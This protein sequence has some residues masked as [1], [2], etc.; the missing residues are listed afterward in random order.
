[1]K[2]KQLL[3]LSFFLLLLCTACE[4]A[5]KKIEYGKDACSFC[6]MTIVDKTHSAEI[7]TKKG[8]DYKYDA[9]EC[10]V[11]DIAKK[12][13]NSLAFILVANYANPGELIDATQ[14]TFLI[15]P[16]IKSPMG[17]NLSAFTNQQ[18]IDQVL[19]NIKGKLYTWSTLK[20]KFK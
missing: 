7:V 9:V 5:P 13:E 18:S 1:M 4:V 14:A 11:N 16:A 20:D 8:K 17:A 6:R 10:L 3:L 15:S 12:E 2:N 19:P